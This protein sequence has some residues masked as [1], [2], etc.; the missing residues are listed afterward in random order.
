MCPGCG[1]G[2]ESGQCWHQIQ[3]VITRRR[4]EG[5]DPPPPPP[6]STSPR[7]GHRPG[8]IHY[9]GAYILKPFKTLGFKITSFF[10]TCLQFAS[11]HL[12]SVCLQ[13]ALI[14]F[15]LL[16]LPSIWFNMVHLYWERAVLDFVDILT[17]TEL[18]LVAKT[19]HLQGD[20]H[21]LWDSVTSF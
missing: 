21:Q 13:F 5:G 9:T 4:S 16:Q 17:F 11:T 1:G 10:F 7:S 12:A 8:N 15:S 18:T 14:S 6:P 19:S 3:I 20:Q 2:L